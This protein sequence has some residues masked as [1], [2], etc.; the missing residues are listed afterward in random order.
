MKITEFMQCEVLIV[1]HN[2]V[3]DKTL[4]PNLN[5]GGNVFLVHSKKLSIIISSDTGV[6]CI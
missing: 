5:R 2:T 1:I 6:G 4:V 3:R